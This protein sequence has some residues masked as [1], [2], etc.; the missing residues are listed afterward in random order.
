[1]RVGVKFAHI[2]RWPAKIGLAAFAICFAWSAV[3]ET[4]QVTTTA[5]SG[6]GSLRQAILTANANPGLDTIVF[7]I[8]GTPPFTITPA[9]ALPAITDPVVIDATTEPGYAGK[10]LIELNGASSGSGTIGLRL[11]IGGTTLRGLAINRFPLQA[12]ELDGPSNVIQGN[13]IGTDV[14]GTIQRDNGAYAILINGSSGNLIGGT[15]AGNGNLVSGG[16]SANSPGIYILTASNN[17]VQGNLIGVNATGTAAFNSVNDGVVLYNSNTNLIGGPTPAAGNIISGNGA[18][19]VYLT[20]KA[21]GNVIQ[22]NRI[23]TG[24]AGT[25]AIGNVAGDGVS[26]IAAP[27]NVVCSNL[28]SGNGLA[29]VSIQSTSGNQVLGNFIGPDINGKVALTNHNSGVSV[30]G[31]GGNQIG[32]ASAGAG[33]VIS[34]NA[35]DGITLTTGTTNNLIQGNLI[36]LTAAGNSALRNVQ[37][38]ITISGATNNTIGGALAGAGNVISGNT[39]NGI[40]IVLATDTGNVVQG[41]YIGT[42]VTGTTAVANK[43]AGIMLAGSS[44]LIGGTVAGAGNVI[45]GNSQQGIWLAGTNGSARGNVIQ[46]NLIGLTASGTASLG[47]GAGGS[48]AGIGISTASAN[49]VGGAA[50]GAGNV[51]SGNNGAGIFL[52]GATSSANTIQ[53]NFIGT[54]PTGTVG[55]ANVFEG[56]YMDQAGTNQIGGGAPGAGN[57]IS[58]NLEGIFL[59]NSSWTVIQGNLIGTKV[60]GTNNLGNIEHNVELQANANNNVIGGAAAGAGNCLA[61]AQGVYCGVRVRTGA[62]ND[63]ISGNSIFNNGALGIDLS[64]TSGGT[65]AG[66]NPIV[67]C[68]EGVV[69]N[70]ANAGQNFPAL[71]NV[72]SG[73]ITEVRGSLNAKTTLTYT[74]QFFASPVGDSSGYGEG[75]VYLGQTNLTLGSSSCSS[76]FTALLPVS[77]PAGWVVT[78]TATDPNNNTSEFSAWVPIIRVPPLQVSLPGLNFLALSWTNNGGSFALEQTTNLTP[79]VVWLTVPY[80]PVPVS[81]FL[82]TTLGMTNR[83][84]FYRLSVP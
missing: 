48:S 37:N 68:E 41:N 33:N 50:P 51:I 9:S 35:L 10:P 21:T 84:V 17:V 66:V 43:L 40:D 31:G 3:G 63:L 80:L 75:Q 44:N 65:A 74:L 8:S 15:N 26:L 77:V 14:T 62:F 25:N 12:L 64:P 32:G 46:G 73:T 70:A 76:N 79:P 27:G 67:T 7:Q 83:S 28:I 56:I 24:I 2:L 42:D 47:N 45:S 60:D 72:Y 18:S 19:G 38:G 81:N 69:A 71:S 16:L 59:T 57:L 36:G 30:S 23:G 1:M 6:A 58:D 20:A 22:G 82:I 55:R 5:D 78:A 34:G 11:T 39:N 52:M 29:G 53:G 54:D 13:F 4:I 61:W 49:W